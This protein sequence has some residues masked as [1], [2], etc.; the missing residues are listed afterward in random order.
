MDDTPNF[1]KPK[2]PQKCIDHAMWQKQFSIAYWLAFIVGFF[3]TIFTDHTGAG[4]AITGLSMLI[5][6]VSF[7]LDIRHMEWHIKQTKEG[8]NDE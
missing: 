4:L 8:K 1:L 2:P 3:L 6:I 7:V 5:F